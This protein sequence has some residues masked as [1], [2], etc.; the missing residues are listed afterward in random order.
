MFD[1]TEVC[2]ISNYEGLEIL[3]TSDQTAMGLPPVTF[4]KYKRDRFNILVILIKF[5]HIGRASVVCQLPCFGRH[6]KLLVLVAFAVVTIHSSFRE[7]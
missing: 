3:H 1:H 4:V 5:G 6:V 2:N 7:G